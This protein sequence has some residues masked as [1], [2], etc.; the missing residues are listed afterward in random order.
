[1]LQAHVSCFLR[2]APVGTCAANHLQMIT[3]QGSDSARYLRSEPFC[4][5]CFLFLLT[6]VFLPFFW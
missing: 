4:Y 5:S 2:E 3:P 6:N 1:V